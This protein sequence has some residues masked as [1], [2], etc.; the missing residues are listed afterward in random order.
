MYGMSLEVACCQRLAVTWDVDATQVVAQ[1]EQHPQT[2]ASSEAVA[3]VRS[4]SQQFVNAR[5]KQEGPVEHR[6]GVLARE[7]QTFQ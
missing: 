3:F 1:V 6:E 5:R 4:T 2:C 7:S